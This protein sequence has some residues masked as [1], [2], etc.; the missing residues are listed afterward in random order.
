MLTVEPEAPRPLRPDRLD[1]EQSPWRD[2]LD[3]PEAPHGSWLWG[4]VSAI[5]IVVLF[6]LGYSR[7]TATRQPASRVDPPGLPELAAEAGREELPPPSSEVR[8]GPDDTLRPDGRSPELADPAKDLQPKEELPPPLKEA[9]AGRQRPREP[10]SATLNRNPKVRTPTRT[11]S[12][13]PRPF[14][15]VITPRK[16]LPTPD[17][18]PPP[19]LAREAPALPFYPLPQSISL[20]RPVETAPKPVETALNNVGPPTPSS[21]T[22]IWTGRLRKNARVVIE[23]KNASLGTVTGELPGKPA[24]Y[25]VYP[26]DLSD[27]GILVFTAHSQDARVGWDSPGPENGWNRILYEVDPHNARGV[28]VEEVPSP[29]NSW[30]RLVL[31]CIN[32]RLSVIYVKWSLAR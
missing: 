2:I 24:Q 26:G 29:A 5:A 19:Q 11:D 27:D 30:R 1:M 14:R 31:K 9:A 13:Q 15:P 23:G 8:P 21:G 25:Q 32:P 7:I 3:E 4:A 6:V 12:H 10:S 18:A 16:N 28:E 22:L 17:L 20:V